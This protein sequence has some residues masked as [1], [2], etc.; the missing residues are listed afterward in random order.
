MKGAISSPRGRIARGAVVGTAA[1]KVSA[2]K[3]RLLLGKPFR[4]DRERARAAGAADEDMAKI[5]FDA[6]AVLRG[7]ALKLAQVLAT[8]NEMFTPAF[9]EQFGR[10]AH[11]AVPINRAL[12]HRLLR[13]ELGDWHQHFSEFCDVPFAAASL[14]QVHAATSRDGEVLALKLQYPG[15][16]EGVAS[17]ISLA[18][19]VLAPTRWG[20]VFESCLDE[21][22]GRLSEELD[23]TQEAEHTTWFRERILSPW[24]RIPRVYDEH[25]TRHILVTERLP[26]KHLTAWLAT[27]PSREAREHY[28]QLLVE[29]FHHSV[30]NLRFFHADP[31][32][33]NYL[34]ADNGQL[35]VIDF[36]CVRRLDAQAVEALRRAY[37][38]H[39]ASPDVIEQIHMKMGVRYRTETSRA[40]LREFLVRWANWV[41]EP[42]RSE[43]FDFGSREYFERGCALGRVARRLVASCDGSFLYFGRAQQGLYRL[44]QTLRVSVHMPIP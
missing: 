44:L 25:S 27:S 35:G 40:E 18:R 16:A 8:E 29:L 23:Y 1:I 7:T 4:D 20:S 9:R 15:V 2:C 21:L 38:P 34:F 10:A 13:A 26:G 17:D 6:C 36:G 33:G 28:G 11:D 24:V 41:W 19:A 31:N 32:F 12:V 30:F 3:A 43:R 14:G 37:S 22:R 39:D 42:Y 5:L